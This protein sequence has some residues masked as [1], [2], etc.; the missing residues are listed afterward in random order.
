MFA[1]PE[2]NFFL[3]ITDFFKKDLYIRLYDSINRQQM[4]TQ[5]VD[6]KK[7]NLYLKNP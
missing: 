1:T 2:C 6:N 5:T 3:K 7:F 4:Q